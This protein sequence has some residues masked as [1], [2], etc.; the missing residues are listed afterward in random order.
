[1]SIKMIKVNGIP[2]AVI[3]ENITA[4]KPITTWASEITFVG[5]QTMTVD[6]EFYNLMKH[7][8][9]IS[10]KELKANAEAAE[11]S[12]KI[13][14]TEHMSID[15]CGFSVR[16]V[17]C[18]KRGGINTVEELKGKNIDDLKKIRNMG[19]SIEEIQAFLSKIN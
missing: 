4:V 11:E 3:L 1:M 13:T 6:M 14:V 18:L 9:G 16:T 10:E 8:Y 7:L 2:N 15:D 5:G 19:R 12:E 17:N